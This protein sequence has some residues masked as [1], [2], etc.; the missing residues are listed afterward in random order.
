MN[1]VFRQ[2]ASRLIERARFRGALHKV[3][4]AQRALIDRDPDDPELQNDFALTF[5]MMGREDDAF[6]VYNDVS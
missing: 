3:L 4:V 6:K 5:L 1:N 2:A